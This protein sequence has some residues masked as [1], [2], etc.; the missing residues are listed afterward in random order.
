MFTALNSLALIAFTLPFGFLNSYNRI[1]RNVEMSIRV[2]VGERGRIDGG[3]KLFSTLMQSIGYVLIAWL[4]F[5]DVTQYGFAITGLLLLVAAI[6]M[7]LLF[8]HRV[9]KPKSTMVVGPIA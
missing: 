6:A 8:S 1:A 5:H 3:L 2:S 9:S 4:S 7:Q